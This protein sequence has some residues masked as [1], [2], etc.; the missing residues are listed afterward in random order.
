[1]QKIHTQFILDKKDVLEEF[2]RGSGPG[3]QHRNKTETGVRLTHVSGASVTA[4]EQ[5]SQHQNRQVAWDRLRKKLEAPALDKH[6]AH[7]VQWD[8]CDWRD[9]V[10]LPDGRRKSMKAVLK[11]GV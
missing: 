2:I 3:G 7:D 1:M 8:W 10:V 4:T 6:V 5:R 9:E 11:K